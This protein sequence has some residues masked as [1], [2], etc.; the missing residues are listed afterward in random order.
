METKTEYTLTFCEALNLMIKEKAWVKGDDFA[1][2][3]YIK[4]SELGK[5]VL[6]DVEDFSLQSD[7]PFIVSLHR[8]KYRVIRFATIKELSK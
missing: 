7:M 6:V 1:K 3:V 2:G 4:I 5:I 8:Q